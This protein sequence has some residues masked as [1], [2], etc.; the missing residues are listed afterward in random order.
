MCCKRARP[1][2][3]RPTSLI[4]DIRD[5]ASGGNQMH[6]ASHPSQARPSE[7][8]STPPTGPAGLLMQPETASAINTGGPLHEPST[9]GRL[10]RPRYARLACAVRHRRRA[11]SSDRSRHPAPPGCLPGAVVVILCARRRLSRR[12]VCR[13]RQ[14]GRGSP[15]PD[16]HVGPSE[17][18][19]GT[20][21][22][23][24]RHVCLHYAAV[25]A[26]YWSHDR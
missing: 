22:P 17:I 26:G 13:I 8:N 18:V 3:G 6:E 25:V 21:G 2:K 7:P 19:A 9:R 23:R 1:H 24:P 4:R 16:R 11:Q 10:L 14:R 20:D 5:R 12:A 15:L